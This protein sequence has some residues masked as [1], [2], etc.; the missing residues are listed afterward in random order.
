MSRGSA[1][2]NLTLNSLTSGSRNIRRENDLIDGMLES[3]RKD[4]R[5][6]E[7][8]SGSCPH[9]E[10][11][12]IEMKECIWCVCMEWVC[13]RAETGGKRVRVRRM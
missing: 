1:V 11:T 2:E 12:W 6:R 5:V 8:E 10:S 7:M 4:V 13:A 9:R 3:G